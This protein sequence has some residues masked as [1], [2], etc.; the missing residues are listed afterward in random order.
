M[1]NFLGPIIE[2]A[3]YRI[4]PDGPADIASLTATSKPTMRGAQGHRLRDVQVGWRGDSI[5][6]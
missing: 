3:G 4:V 6:R 2:A 1:R 5:Y